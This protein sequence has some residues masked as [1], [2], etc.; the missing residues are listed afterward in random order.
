MALKKDVV[1]TRPNFDGLLIHRNGY[2]KITRIYGDKSEMRFDVCCIVNTEINQQV[3]KYFTPVLDGKNFIAQ[4]Y[5]YLKT[6][7][8][9][10]G[11]QDC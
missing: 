8:E 3:S 9:F 4:A 5:D 2:W 11:A 10:E 1:I 7:P 6:L